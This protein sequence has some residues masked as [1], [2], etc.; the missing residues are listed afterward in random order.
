MHKCVCS[1]EQRYILNWKILLCE[2]TPIVSSN[3]M[4]LMLSDAKIASL[5]ARVGSSLLGTFAD[6]MTHMSHR[7]TLTARKSAR[8][9]GD[10]CNMMNIYIYIDKM[11]IVYIVQSSI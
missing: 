11:E 9:S 10:P 1:N 7:L 4:A 3:V 6:R 5:S 8:L 2:R